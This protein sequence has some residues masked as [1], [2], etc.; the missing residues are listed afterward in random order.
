MIAREWPEWPEWPVVPAGGQPPV[1]SEAY[2]GGAWL[3]SGY[4]EVCAALRDP[5]FS[6]RRAA[7]WINSGMAAQPDPG[8]PTPEQLRFKRIFARSLLFLDGRAH[9]R[10]RGVVNTG[11][12]PADL[13]QQ[14]PVIAAIA[15]RLIAAI[16]IDDDA[17]DEF[18]F[19]ERFARPL[20]ALVI[21][22]LMGLP[23]SVPDAFIAWAA[24]LAA[25]IGSPTPDARQT[26][27]ARQAMAD[28]CDFFSHALAA[29]DM[30]ANGMLARIAEARQERRLTQMEA[31][32]QCC[33][34]L[35]AGYETTRNLLGNGLL[36]LLRH[37][38]QWA[39]LQSE[40]QRLRMAVREMLRYDSP[41]QYTGRRLLDDVE[42]GG[43]RLRRGDLAILHIGAANHD[44]RRFS[45]P[46]RFD[47]GRD[48]GNH[49]SFGHGP[50]VCLGAALT[51][52]EAEIAFSALM[53]AMPEMTLAAD[54]PTWQT[55][56]AYRALERL[57]V[58]FRSRT[59][60]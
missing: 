20:P 57:P 50:H 26:L 7:R 31:L 6:V 45:D 28:M 10:L 38:D 53:R 37:P 59:H 16:E 4:E 36:A 29:P 34:L 32:A 12:K 51:Q 17:R 46:D 33:T 54:A 3:L 35:F 19:V 5:R 18:D 2:C 1:W 27:V 48:E 58:A 25:F 55:T 24:D 21:A 40:P 47:I 56:S 60:A 22:S 52:L 11:F 49:L 41:V 42:I 43:R 30:P 13:Q 9:R 39:A 23:A 44:P 14:A 15:E 8:A